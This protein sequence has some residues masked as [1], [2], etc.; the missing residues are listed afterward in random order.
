MSV[1]FMLLLMHHMQTQHQQPVAQ[2]VTV[3]QQPAK[4][5]DKVPV[6]LVYYIDPGKKSNFVGAAVQKI[7]KPDE[8]AAWAEKN[9]KA[10]ILDVRTGEVCR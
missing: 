2:L 4:P 8:I 7:G 1:I 9:P 5:C 3:Q 10:H 6:T